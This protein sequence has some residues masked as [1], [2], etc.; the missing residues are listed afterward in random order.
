MSIEHP[1]DP[2][3]LRFQ[4]GVIATALLAGYVFGAEWV[5]P[6]LAV[7]LAAAGL[8]GRRASVFYFAFD[9]VVAP[10]LEASTEREDSGMVRFSTL[11]AAA[12][13]GVSTALVAVGLGGIAWILALL[14]AA[15]EAISAAAS[16]PLTRAIY[17]RFKSRRS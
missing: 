10:R 4:G 12:V 11:F 3:F 8:A 2:R 6:I 13:L 17:E 7:A 1:L 16:I 5:L 9:V 15:V 14:L